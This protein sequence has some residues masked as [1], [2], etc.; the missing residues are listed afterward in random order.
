MSLNWLDVILLVILLITFILGL[1]KG[2][3]RQLIGIVAVVA[4]IML[5]SRY[6]PYVS[7]RLHRL[8]SSDFW[9]NCLSF[10]LIFLTAV[11][12]GWLIGFLLSKLMKGPLSLANHFLGGILGIIKGLLIGAVIVFSFLTFNFQREV[13]IGSRLSPVCLKVAR[14][15]TVFI[16]QGLKNNFNEAWK[17]F[18]GKGGGHEQKI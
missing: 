15:L 7:W 4:G 10:L 14:A 17:K 12:L 3:I 18:E 16:P 11:L 5:A 6:Y 9:R 8:I 2:L 1:V 13:L